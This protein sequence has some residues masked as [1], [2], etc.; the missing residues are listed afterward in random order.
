[1]RYSGSTGGDW[2][3]QG[4][5]ALWWLSSGS[6]NPQQQLLTRAIKRLHFVF[7]RKQSLFYPSVV[8]FSLKVHLH[9]RL[10]KPKQ[11]NN[12]RSHILKLTQLCRLQIDLNLPFL[13]CEI[14]RNTV[15][16]RKIITRP[17]SSVS[18]EHCK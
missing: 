2:E 14:M 10:K 6:E 5:S 4:C 3:Q 9:N 11:N 13:L 15:T 17:A 1:R 16:G 12:M 7:S 18:D 8:F